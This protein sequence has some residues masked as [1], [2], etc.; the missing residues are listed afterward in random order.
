MF[1]EADEQRRL[2]DLRFLLY[3]GFHF[4]KMLVFRVKL[5]SDNLHLV[6]GFWCVAEFARW[7]KPFG[8]W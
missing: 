3:L 2:C 7:P 5:C 1:F 6:D 4:L 8:A